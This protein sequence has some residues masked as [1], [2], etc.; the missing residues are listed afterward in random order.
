LSIIVANF[1]NAV[2]LDECL[3]SV[4]A[5]TYREFEVVVVDDASTDASLELIRSWQVRHP[6]VVR[7]ISNPANL[8]V[9]RSRH[10]AIDASRGAW[11]TTLDS[12]DY[13]EHPQ[14]LEREMALATTRLAAGETVMA[15]SDIALVRHDRTAMGLNSHRAPVREGLISAEILARSCLIP[16]DFVMPRSAYLA[17]GGY[18]VRIPIYEDWDLKI[19]LAE[20]YPFCFSGVVGTAY[21]RHGHGLSSA[22]P[23]QHIAWLTWVFEQHI[24]RVEPGRREAVRTGFSRFLERVWTA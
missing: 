20:R 23:D 4:F 6:D 7:V 19:R 2:F 13:Y 21:R 17:V 11:L 24:A 15:F 5:Q 12:D 22:P 10:L 1:N 9:A 16:R 18:D 3:E 8:G 14:K